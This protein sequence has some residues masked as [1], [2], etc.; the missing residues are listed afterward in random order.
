MS[1]ETCHLIYILRK[2][3]V[4]TCDW[5]CDREEVDLILARSIFLYLT[6][7]NLKDANCLVD[8][9]RK[10]LGE[11]NFPN[12]PLMQFIKY[13]L[14][15][16]ERDALPLLHSLR[17]SYKDHLARDSTLIEYLDAITEKFYGVQQKN[18]LQ[19]MLGDFMKMFGSE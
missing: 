15:T 6:L 3:T 2:I 7:G 5:Q 16:L 13:L 12:T 1:S 11:R 14:L 10:R 19:R 17:E 9:V 18:G 4:L 8:E